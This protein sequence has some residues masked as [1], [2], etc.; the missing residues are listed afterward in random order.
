MLALEP[1]RAPVT[2]LEQPCKSALNPVS[3]MG[4]KWSL[5][6]Y[7]GCEHR[8]TFCYVRAYEL[9][10]DRPS[11]DGYGRT[12][13]VKVNVA[14]VLRREL[15]R[16][17]WRRETVVIGAATD[18]YQPA[19]GRYRLTR[20]CLQ[21]LHDFATPASLITRSPM[22]VRD[23][24]VLSR[25]AGRAE[26]S[27]SFSL[28]T[29]DLDVWRRT[30]PGTAPPGQRL[31]A[32]EKLVGA[33]IRAGVAMAPILPGISDR[34]EQLEA[35]VKAAREA[36]ATNLWAGMLHLRPGTREHFLESLARHWPQLLPRYQAMY[37]RGAYLPRPLAEPALSLVGD[38]K[39]R[40][41]IADRRSLRLEPPTP[42][43]TPQQLALLA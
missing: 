26:V 2:F 14:E 15:A 41:R 23:V 27:V 31:R 4:F 12:V 40:H 25:L 3:G 24:D 8:C 22:V 29:L 17:R 19:E 38:L 20:S 1:R 16:P 42:P 33:G 36:G 21:A 5:N 13:R 18:P 10:A 37:A 30:E 43:P 32:L 39:Q 34:P 7:M 35:V 9:R 28:P 6:P 11:G